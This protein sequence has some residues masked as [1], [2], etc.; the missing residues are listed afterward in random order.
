[1]TNHELFWLYIDSL[2]AYNAQNNLFKLSGKWHVDLCCC[3]ECK[4]IK[5][6]E[7]LGWWTRLRVKLLY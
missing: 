4:I 3:E 7:S 1:M 5:K 6:W 2:E